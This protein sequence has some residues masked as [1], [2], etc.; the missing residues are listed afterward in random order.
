MT[1]KQHAIY[2]QFHPGADLGLSRGWGRI[3]KKKR[4]FCRPFVLDRPN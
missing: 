2:E 1:D 4:L 3:L